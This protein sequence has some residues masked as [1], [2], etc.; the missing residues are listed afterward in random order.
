MN[1]AGLFSA[2][3]LP[4]C[5]WSCQIWQR[6]NDPGAHSGRHRSVHQGRCIGNSGGDQTMG[7]IEKERPR[8]R[9]ELV[10]NFCAILRFW[11]LQDMLVM[12]TNG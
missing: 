6:Q 7:G 9:S 12:K 3:C 1:W 11:G 5:F 10:I 2:S 8:G 4:C